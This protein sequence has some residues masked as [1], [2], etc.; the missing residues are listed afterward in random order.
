MNEKIS[1]D[2]LF[3]FCLS[4][5]PRYSAQSNISRPTSASGSRPPAIVSQSQ[6][7]S[8]STSPHSLRSSQNLSSSIRTPTNARSRIPIG[9]NNGSRISSRE[10]SPGRT[11]KSNSLNEFFTS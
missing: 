10:S 2:I 3:F 6:P 9:S 7:G 11:R 8:R 1:F 4:A 5:R